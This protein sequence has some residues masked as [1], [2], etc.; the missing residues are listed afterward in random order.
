MRGQ[1]KQTDF[2]SKLSVYLVEAGR[3]EPPSERLLV[4][5]A[6]I[7]ILRFLKIRIKRT[8]LRHP[9]ENYR[10]NANFFLRRAGFFPRVKKI[11][12]AR[13]LNCGKNRECISPKEWAAFCYDYVKTIFSVRIRQ[14]ADPKLSILNKVQNRYLNYQMKTGS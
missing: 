12:R 2:L 5:D 8:A 1:K 14:I 9:V 10:L 7:I 13:K 3:V 11:K 4:H 6:A